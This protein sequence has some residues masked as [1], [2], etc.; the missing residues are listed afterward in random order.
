M[1]AQFGPDGLLY[2]EAASAG[3]QSSA[4]DNLLVFQIKPGDPPAIANVI[5]ITNEI[6]TQFGGARY[7][8]QP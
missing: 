2:V 5:D 1:E 6:A 3:S 4:E 7:A 8:V